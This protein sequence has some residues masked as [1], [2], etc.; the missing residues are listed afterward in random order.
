MK[1][2]WKTVIIH[3]QKENET[4]ELY[5]VAANINVALS[6][7]KKRLK[8]SLDIKSELEDLTVLSVERLHEVEF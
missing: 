1:S 5:G 2:M 4:I 6:K 3:P 8:E 7:S